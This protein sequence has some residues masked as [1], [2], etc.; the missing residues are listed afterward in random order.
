MNGAVD[1]LVVGAAHLDEGVHW[2]AERLGVAPVPGG[3]HEGFGTRNALLGLGTQ[4]LEVLAPDPAQPDATS[5]LAESV[6]ALEHPTLLT[7]AIAKHDLT[8]PVPMSRLRPDGVLLH[9]ELQFTETPLFFI[10]W[11]DS[12]RPSGLPDGGRISS[13]TITTP[14]PELLAGIEGVTAVRGPWHIEASI[15]GMPLA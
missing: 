13:L 12:P 11:K 3:V 7:V 5:S 4:Y 6:R 2:L 9:W 14:Q 1:H 10:D 15:N 8:N